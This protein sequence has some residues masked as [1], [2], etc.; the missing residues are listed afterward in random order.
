MAPWNIEATRQEIERVH[1]RRQLELARPC[2]RSLSDR[3][4]YAR[5]HYQRTRST[6]GRYVKQHLDPDDPMPTIFGQDQKGWNRFNVVIRKL[7]ADVTACIQSIH[8][9]P[10]IL[11]SAVYFAL[12]LDRSSKP[13]P[14]KFVNHGFVMDATA[15]VPALKEVHAGLRAAT[16]GKAWGHL[17]A[18]ANQSKHYS[19]VFPALNTDLTGERAEK[20]MP[21][22]PS[23]IARGKRYPQVFVSEFLPPIY[24]QVSQAVQTTGHALHSCLRSAA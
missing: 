3:Q 5:F 20:H 4:F 14:G 21:V 1:G 6:L 22:L 10:D 19:I 17:A 23:F 24:S 8:A 7:G 9:V 13:G 12:A 11:A 15:G 2:L 16:A 18:L